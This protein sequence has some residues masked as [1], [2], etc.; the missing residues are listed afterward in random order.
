MGDAKRAQ[1]RES[2]A[3]KVL[4]LALD[5]A[6]HPAN[7]FDSEVFTRGHRNPQG[8][9]F[10]GGDL[11]STEHGPA[12]ADEINLLE[13]GN[14]YGWPE[15]KGERE[16][17]DDD[18]FTDP[19]VAYTPTVAP[20]SATFYDGP[21]EQWRGDFFFGTLAGRHLHRVRFDGRDA[22]EQE[23]LYEGEFGRLRTVF[24]GPNGHLYCTTSN[25]DGRGNPSR[26][27]DGVL[28]FASG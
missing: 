19:L 17:G 3:G 14:N 24:A 7:P 13:A 2:L 4:R 26:G 12:T 27:D 1:R 16:G 20:G 10:R 6:A 25:R 9:A 22:V 5:G 23:R 21:I 11:F 28:R 18:E 8:L 15:V